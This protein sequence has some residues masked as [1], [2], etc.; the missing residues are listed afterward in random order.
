VISFR[1]AVVPALLLIG[2]LLRFHA[3]D[4]QSLWDDEVATLQTIHTPASQLVERH[5]TYETHPPLY[6]LQLRVWENVFGGSLRALRANSALW[7]TLSLA[8]LYAL[9]APYELGLLVLVLFVFSPLHLAYSQELR[10]YAFGVFLALAS[11]WSVQ[12]IVGTAKNKSV[13]AGGDSAPPL[14]VF[15]WTCLLFTHYWG[16]FVCLVQGVYGLIAASS[17]SQRSKIVL[18]GFSSVALFAF[19]IPVFL[20]QLHVIGDLA[21][22]VPHASVGA[23]GETFIAYT[24]IAFKI[25]SF[26]FKIPG[27]IPILILLG[28]LQAALVLWGFRKAPRFAQVWLAALLLPW[29]LS[30][31]LPSLYVWYR[32]P[33]FM[34]PAFL[35]VLATGVRHVRW[36]A[37][38]GIVLGVL[39]GTQVVG[40]WTYFSGWQ[41][42]N[43]KAVVAFIDSYAPAPPLVVRPEYFSFL[44]NYYDREHIPAL[45][46][47]TL[48]SVEK[49]AALHGHIIFLV[50]F[51]VPSDPIRDAFLTEYHVLGRKV[52]PGFAHLGIT[53][54]V[55]K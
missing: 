29:M 24:G 48:D 10:P 20:R 55:L 45:D 23:L 16:A 42:A 19:W 27:P 8:I 33:V 28:T 38:R 46:T 18:S 40:V 5:A 6:F 31:R 9:A 4:H 15:L 26:A 34:L 47:H 54:Y 52:F 30:Y 53:V 14:Q 2:A 50:A 11:W 39:I 37:L 7:G 51:D 32:Y 35:V 13:N 1:R 43:P 44:Y 41:K 17:R 12:R 25:A 22:W 49:R 21:F 36:P 3:L